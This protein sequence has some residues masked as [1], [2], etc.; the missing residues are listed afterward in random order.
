MTIKL[1]ALLEFCQQ[2]GFEDL[3]GAQERYV[4]LEL[5]TDSRVYPSAVIN[6]ES[7]KR[8]D[9]ASKIV[10][11]ELAESYGDACLAEL[12]L[13]LPGIRRP[14]SKIDYFSH[15]KLPL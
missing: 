11:G 2:V 13:F 4:V 6:D 5:T 9:F 15:R 3:E 12:L 8:A 14:V 7:D 1:P 10:L